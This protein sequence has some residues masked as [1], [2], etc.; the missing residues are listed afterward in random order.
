MDQ[1]NF[2]GIHIL[3]KPIDEQSFKNLRIGRQKTELPER[4][5][6][7]S[8]LPVFRLGTLKIALKIKIGDFR[9]P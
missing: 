9:L 5:G 8:G 4:T 2:V 3:G 1:N 7:Y 6:S